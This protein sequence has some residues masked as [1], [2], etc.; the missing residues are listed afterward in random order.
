[1][2]YYEDLKICIKVRM[3]SFFFNFILEFKAFILECFCSVVLYLL[4]TYYS[5][6]NLLIESDINNMLE[7]A[8]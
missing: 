7:C 3:I 6:A 1:M 8:I 4:F 5:A 2:S